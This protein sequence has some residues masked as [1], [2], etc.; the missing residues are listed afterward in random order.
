MPRPPP[1]QEPP[2][3]VRGQRGSPGAALT[4]HR[5]LGLGVCCGVLSSASR[6]HLCFSPADAAYG[7]GAV[8][9]ASMLG[10]RLREAGW[11]VAVMSLLRPCGIVGAEEQ[12][13]L[14]VPKH[15]C[16]AQLVFIS[17]HLVLPLEG[18]TCML[19]DG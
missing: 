2:G 11:R 4:C 8:L 18:D 7:C 12:M 6:L 15:F 16:H 14:W 5:D 17:F 10:A 3:L 19:Y 13:S 1:A 9:L